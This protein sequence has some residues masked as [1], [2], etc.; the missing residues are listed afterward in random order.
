[1]SFLCLNICIH[2]KNVVAAEEQ[3]CWPFLDSCC[4]STVVMLESLKRSV[5]GEE[6]V[7]CEM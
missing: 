2:V 7:L 4:L 6:T 1:M 5:W 3:E